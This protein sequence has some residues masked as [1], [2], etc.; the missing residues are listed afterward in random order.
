MSQLP[1]FPRHL[2]AAIHGGQGAHFD[3]R[4]W[5]MADFPNGYVPTEGEVQ[6]QAVPDAAMTELRAKLAAAENATARAEAEL[7]TVRAEKAIAEATIQSL[8]GSFTDLEEEADGYRSAAREASDG[9]AQ[10][11]AMVTVLNQRIATLQGQTDADLL[12]KADQADRLGALLRELVPPDAT[13]LA[14]AYTTEQ[15]RAIGV[16]FGLSEEATGAA[17]NKNALADLVVQAMPRPP[18]G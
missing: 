3:G 14:R 7:A 18:Q 4:V 6:A 5:T 15:L 13:A 8:Q 2:A 9:R 12:R 16:H 17:Q 11:E 1:T 10:A